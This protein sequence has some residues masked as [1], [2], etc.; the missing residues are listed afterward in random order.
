MANAANRG[1]GR[2]MCDGFELFGKNWT[3]GLVQGSFPLHRLEDILSTY[4]IPR[5]DFVK[6]DVEGYECEVFMGAPGFFSKYHPRLIK[7]EVW[8][9]VESCTMTQYLDI[10]RNNSYKVAN[11]DDVDCKEP[12]SNPEEEIM[13]RN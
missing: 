1:N 8:N 2:V 7:T 9:S 3:D 5:I 4:P 11:W 13:S 12:V 6:L 10:F